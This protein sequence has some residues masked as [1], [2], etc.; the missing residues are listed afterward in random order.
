M[1]E[2]KLNN[3]NEITRNANNWVVDAEKSCEKKKVQ[4]YLNSVQSDLRQK[5]EDFWKQYIENRQKSFTVRTLCNAMKHN[6]ALAFEELYEPYD[7]M[8]I[9]LI[10]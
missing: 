3:R 10:M 6:H 7:F 1:R 4:K 8:E 2:S 5:I 9:H